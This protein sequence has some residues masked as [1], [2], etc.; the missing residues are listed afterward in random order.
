M[1][2][3]LTLRLTRAHIASVDSVSARF[4]SWHHQHTT[5]NITAFYCLSGLS[6][7]Q[8]LRLDAIR[9]LR[10]KTKRFSDKKSFKMFKYAVVFNVLTCKGSEEDILHV[11]PIW[12]WASA[13]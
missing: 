4:V 13:F 7:V 2:L 10:N 9:S 11:L 5:Q 6:Q 8:L 1:L 12:M 3:G